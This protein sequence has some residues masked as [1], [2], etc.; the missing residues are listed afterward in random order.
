MIT[1]P[2]FLTALCNRKVGPRDWELTDDL[3]FES[4]DLG[5]IVVMPKGARYNGASTPRFLWWL[6][7]PSGA[8]DYGVAL[9][10]GAYR[11]LLVTR[12]G[13]R[14]RLI[15]RLADRLMDEANEA[16]GVSLWERTIL[17]RGVRLFGRPHYSGVPAA[18]G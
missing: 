17:Y 13:T 18:I 6:I 12:D 5:G 14:I 8:F 4:R 3:V 15:Q 2:R 16:T 11:G 10:D 7:P 1:A 9:H